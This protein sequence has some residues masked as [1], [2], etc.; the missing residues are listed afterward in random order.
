[1]NIN[2][3][4]INYLRCLSADMITTANS[5]HPGVALGATTILY[6]LFKDHY[7]YDIKD[8]KFIA[9]DRLILSA[10]H[11]SALYYATAYMF[12]FGLTE[13]DLKNFRKLDSKTP[14][15]PE[16][17]VTN[18]VETS[19]GPLGQGV[20][21]A[22]GMAIG[23]N[24]IGKRFNAQKCPVVDN[25]TYC[26]V[27][28]GCLMEGVAQE[29]LSL[30]GTLKLNKLILLYD[31]NNVT[32]DG[33]ADMANSENIAKKFKAMHFNVI[34][35]NNGNNYYF[36]TRAIA[37]AKKCTTKPTIIIFKT[38]IGYGTDKAGLNSIHGKPLTPAE[39][40]QL[41]TKLGVADP[42]KLPDDVKKVA[43]KTIERNANLIE[44]WNNMFAIYQTTNPEL[45]RQL[46]AFMD[47]KKVDVYKLVREE[48]LSQ[49]FSGRDANE[50]IL[51]EL[52]LKM[53]RLVGGTADLASSTKAYIAGAGDYSATNPRGKNIHFG[54]RE[55]AM[56]AI[57]NGLT[58]YL[59][60]PTFCSTFLTFSNYM[61][62][63]IRMSAL[64]NI[65]VMYMFSHDS[66]KVGEDG[67]THQSVEQLSTL[68]LIPNV[69]VFRPCDIRE[70][71]CCYDIALNNDCPSCFV[72]SKQTLTNQ[73]ADYKDIIKGGYILSGSIGK[74][75][76]MATGSE[77]ELAMQVKALLAKQNI[78]TV[79]ASFPCIEEFER[80]SNKYKQD[81]LSR[82]EI[83]VSLE[84]SN[85]NIWYKYLGEK[86]LKISI[87]NFGKSA[88]GS[89]L[90][91]YF[92]FTPNQ[93]ANKIKKHLKNFE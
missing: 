76:I 18:F 68:R 49:S 67:P 46:V 39:L 88:N 14:G 93:V 45:Y 65:P 71:L 47:S 23:Q 31:Y 63:P 66:Y 74:V 28:D 79:V 55:H 35:V 16:Y 91:E 50:I 85:D 15:H 72:L 37:K 17:G 11:A 78:E 22:V 84:A 41:K 83:K 9:R 54:I 10:G 32:I 89:V 2:Q 81:L 82:G 69:N 77:V 58:L 34:K 21:N 42:Y 40:N 38:T 57:C 27:G 86:G 73:N 13:N 44:K 61:I 48:L 51:K 56:G 64:M 1:M 60:S 5:G 33:N 26:F 12:N 53:P 92:G 4:C 24:M 8:H 29:A 90:D 75:L 87:E 62:P 52:S 70:L 36:V 20:A 80:Q 25:Y 7:F 30:A 3:K 43:Q 19:T 6:A 59:S